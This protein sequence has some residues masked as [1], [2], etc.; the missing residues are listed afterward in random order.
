MEYVYLHVLHSV[1]SSDPQQT[2]VVYEKKK[3]SPK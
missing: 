3:K 2:G 1:S